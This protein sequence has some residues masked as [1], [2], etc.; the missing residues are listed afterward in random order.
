[1]N[2]DLVIFTF[3]TGF[4]TTTPMNTV[5]IPLYR[6]LAGEL[7]G[8]GKVL[9]VLH[10]LS[11][12]P[13]ALSS[14]YSSLKFLIKPRLQQKTRNLFIYK[15]LLLIP[16][17]ALEKYPSLIKAMKLLLGWQ[18]RMATRKIEMQNSCRVVMVNDPFHYH[19]FGLVKESLAVYDCLDE[20]SLYGRSDQPSSEVL[21]YERQLTQ[22]A[23]LIFTTSNIL[24]EKMQAQHNDVFLIPN[25]VD[26]DFFNQAM[27]ADTHIAP[28]LEK[29]P[30]PRIGF[31]G[32]LTFWYNFE[33]LY[34][35]IKRR[36]NWN[37]VFIGWVTPYPSCAKAI[38]TIQEMP[39]TY[40]LGRQEFA[41]LPSFLKGFDAAIMPYQTTGAGPTVNPDKMYQY[42][43]AGVPIVA[44]PTPEIAQFSNV[45]EVA[46]SI[47]DFI[48]ALE[49][50]LYCDNSNRIAQQI[51][52]A[53]NE[54]WAKRA[55]LQ[56]KL[57]EKY[58]KIN[59][60]VVWE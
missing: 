37:F 43:A 38:R 50:C 56:V 27:G 57:F 15:P 26:F 9:V 21:A 46:S 18:L 14:P 53:Q 49:R 25:A 1:M 5:R 42:M 32:N 51:A 28:A 39:N 8:K 3:A 60:K 45:I 59:R 41:N 29:I 44:T 48:R 12:I 20:Y 47:E 30:N 10:Y 4:D 33:L 16:L 22:K 52:I 19:L 34:Q 24:Y 7:R 58:L 2:F 17:G 6:A 36:P 31:M 13:D 54:T 23:H 11:I 55:N 35:V 40:F